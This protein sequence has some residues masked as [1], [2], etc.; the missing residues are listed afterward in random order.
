MNWSAVIVAGPLLGAAA[1]ADIFRRR[2][3]N[4]LNIAVALTG[5]AASAW[6]GGGSGLLSSLGAA[7]LLG[8]LLLPAWRMRALGGGD[9]KLAVACGTWIGLQAIVAFGLASAFCGGVIGLVC[10]ASSEQRVRREISENLRLAAAGAMPAVSIAQVGG[11]VSVPYGA[12]FAAAAM[13][14]IT[15]G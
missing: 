8:A 6:I 13:W 3:P 7:V 10:W 9:L 5:T 4:S 2:I 1:L 11:R 15:C 12:G 14:L